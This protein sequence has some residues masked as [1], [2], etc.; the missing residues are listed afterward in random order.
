QVQT[1]EVI[2]KVTERNIEAAKNKLQEK[3]LPFTEIKDDGPGKIVV[4]LPDSS[5]SS[6]IVSELKTDFG[7]GWSLD[8]R[9]NSVTATLDDA[10]QNDLRNRATE[11]AKS[12]IENRV[13]AFGVTEPTIQ[14]HGGEGS[15]QIL[16]EMPGVDD[17]ERVK[18]TLNADSNLEIRL[19]AK[20]SSTYATKEEA[21][22]A[23]KTL[24][25]GADQYE[26]FE[27]TARSDAGSSGRDGWVILE[28]NVVVTGLEM[29]DARAMS[30]SVGAQA[31]EI[32][33]S[34]TA[35]GASRFGQVTG[36]H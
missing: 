29:R 16:I 19:Q 22:T 1:D 18:N 10:A 23:S 12:I 7:Q 14:R 15:Y 8:E 24:P 31:Y 5:K 27:Y 36:Q 21:E 32:S 20:N 35:G 28:K 30:A 26:V 13:N 3:N 34:L 9:G 33:F 2:K 17:P 11:Q 25:G 6:D 4:T